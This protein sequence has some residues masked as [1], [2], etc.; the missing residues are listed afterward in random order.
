MNAE[1][2][3]VGSEMLTPERVDT[4][5]L[6]LTRQLNNLGVE[7]VAKGVVGDDREFLAAA[8]RV[9]LERCSIVIL[10]GG[11]GPTEDDVTREAVAT[12]L[13]RG[14]SLS[15]EVLR[16]LERRF[17]LAKRT[18]AENNRRQAL[19]VDGAEALPNTRGTAPGQW[20]REGSA[21]LLLLPGPPHEMQAMFELEGL[22][23]LQRLVPP[24]AIRTVVLRVIGIGESDLDLAIAPVY[25]RYANPVTS[26]LAANGEI[27]VWLRASCASLEEADR[28]LAEVAAPI[29]SILGDKIYSR[30]NQPLEA[31]VGG[32]LRAAG[33]TV[34]VAESCTGGMLGERFTSVPG[35][36]DYFAGGFIVYTEAAK[37]ELLGVNPETLA[38]FGAVSAETAGEMALGARRRCGA[39][40]ALAIT[41]VAGPAPSSAPDG[42]EIP[43]GSVYMA[44]AGPAGTRAAHRVFLSDRQRVRTI[45]AQFALDLLRRELLGLI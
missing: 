25:K 29:G 12:A 13:G 2:I 32:L 4:N 19:V 26:V 28:L 35:S 1:I 31:V 16:A 42:S 40:Y 18:M 5:S 44:L 20:V 24:V 45:A 33:A 30:E 38:R 23:R 7:V 34:A 21:A 37:R 9:A 6:Y 8:I 3:A 27:Q 39:T 41:G 10:T 15:P 17:D 14:L 22:P 11:L 43:A 36:S